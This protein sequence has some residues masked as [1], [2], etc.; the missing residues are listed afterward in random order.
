[1]A[2]FNSNS[3]DTVTTHRSRLVWLLG[4][5]RDDTIAESSAA[6]NRRDRVIF[7]QIAKSLHDLK[8][9]IEKGVARGR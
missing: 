5:L 6:K 4:L 2:E 1:M 8:T 3:Q 9:R 7:R